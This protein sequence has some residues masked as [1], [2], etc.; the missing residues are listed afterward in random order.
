MFLWVMIVD[1]VLYMWMQVTRFDDVDSLE[2]EGLVT[3]E[4][5]SDQ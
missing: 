4:G 2:G 3:P 1:R 5:G